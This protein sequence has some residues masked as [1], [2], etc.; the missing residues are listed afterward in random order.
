M[1]IS[2]SFEDGYTFCILSGGVTSQDLLDSLHSQIHHDVCTHYCWIDADKDVRKKR[3]QQRS[4]DE[5]DNIEHFD[6]IDS[7][8]TAPEQLTIS[9]GTF[10]CLDTTK[11]RPEEIMEAILCNFT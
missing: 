3:K 5:A 7:L 9:N 1:L 10:Q 6:F 4:R 8:T 2:N 11:K